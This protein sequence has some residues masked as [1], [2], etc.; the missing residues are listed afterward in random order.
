MALKLSDSFKNDISSKNTNLI[1]IVNIGST[2]GTLTSGINIS[3]QSL[4]FDGP[5]FSQIF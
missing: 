2:D 5:K 1:P 4:I 3:T